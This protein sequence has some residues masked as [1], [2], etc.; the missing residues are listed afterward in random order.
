MISRVSSFI[1]VLCVLWTISGC[2]SVSVAAPAGTDGESRYAR[3]EQAEFFG[4][5]YVIAIAKEVISGVAG[6]TIEISGDGISVSFAVVPAPADYAIG[7]SAIKYGEYIF[8]VESEPGHFSVSGREYQFSP[9]LQYIFV[10]GALV[11][12]YSR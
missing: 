8:V 2:R 4:R 6:Q 12:S 7:D 10:N 11:G 3:I 9:D 5:P 1:T